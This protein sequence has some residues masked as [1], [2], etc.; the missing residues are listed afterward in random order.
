MKKIIEKPN[1]FSGLEKEVKDWKEGKTKW[2]TTLVEKDGSRIVFEESLPESKVRLAKANR[3][4]IIRADLGITQTEL[5]NALQVSPRS[6]QGWEIGRPMPDMVL[7][8]AELL[9]DLPAVRKRL[10]VA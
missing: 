10:L 5:A 2:R 9:H 4:K 3:L 8:L 7:L 1:R 6:I